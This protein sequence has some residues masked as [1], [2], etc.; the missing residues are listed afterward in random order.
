MK[1]RAVDLF[2]TVTRIPPDIP[3]RSQN[4]DRS[5]SQGDTILLLFRNG[6]IP[7]SMV[8]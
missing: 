8:L 5:A 4:E 3:L 2:K 6:F 1:S 7:L